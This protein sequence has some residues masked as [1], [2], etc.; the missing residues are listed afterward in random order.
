MKNRTTIL[1]RI[2]TIL[3]V[4]FISLFSLLKYKYSLTQDDIYKKNRFIQL[5]NL[6]DLAIYSD[7]HFIRS[8]SLCSVS[9]IYQIDGTLREY[10]FGSFIY[11]IDK[12]GSK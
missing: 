11:N 2:I 8:R 9:D 3:I 4:S 6:P 10:Q 7:T 5:T 12:K 1:Y